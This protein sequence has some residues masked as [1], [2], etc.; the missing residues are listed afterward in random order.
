MSLFKSLT[1]ALKEARFNPLTILHS[2][3]YAATVTYLKVLKTILRGLGSDQA[4]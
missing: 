4:N 1:Y 3:F 2:M